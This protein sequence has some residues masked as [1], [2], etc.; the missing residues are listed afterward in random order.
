M[1]ASSASGARGL[2][3]FL[4][5]PTGRPVRMVITALAPDTI[6]LPPAGGRNRGTGYLIAGSG[7]EYRDI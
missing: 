6:E 2:W 5:G 1:R 3:G 4:A 7:N